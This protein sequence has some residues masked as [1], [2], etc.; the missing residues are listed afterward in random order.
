[1][2]I[3]KI[4]KQILALIAIPFILSGC[5][6]KSDCE[7]PSRHV[8]KYLDVKKN[9]ETYIDSEK[10]NISDF[11]WKSDYIE[12]TDDDAMFYRTKKDLFEGKN[13][14]NYLYK[15]M[16]SKHDYLKF[17]Y[18]YTTDEYISMTDE[19]GN[20]CGYW[21]STT[22][23]GWTDNPND[24]DNTGT[25]RLYHYRFFGYRIIY[26][27][28]EYVKERSPLVDDIR[29]II[30]DYPYFD[31]DCSS[32]VYREYKTDR[33]QLKNLRIQDFDV[34]HGPDLENKE[35]YTNKK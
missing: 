14:W 7:L 30:D 32:T 27:N 10:M 5:S 19:D 20:E 3:K 35:L 13:N 33:R 17:Y 26:K 16:A 24:S 28:G 21:S 12:I 1:M 34:F 11:N 25:Y 9:I 29:D 8:H 22:H 31:V 2:K 18:E 4:Y 23:S 15:V 6:K